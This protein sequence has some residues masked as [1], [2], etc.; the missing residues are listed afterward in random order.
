[1]IAAMTSTTDRGA[2]LHPTIAPEE[3]DVRHQFFVRSNPAAGRED[4]YNRWY[5][6][7]HLPDVLRIP[8][9]VSAQ[10]FRITAPH[11]DEPAPEFS[12]LAIY[13]IDTE[14]LP[15]VM[16]QLRLR[17]GTP[18]MMMSDALDL[19]TTSGFMGTPIGPRRIAGKS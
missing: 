10:R 4:D 1:M 14:D 18:A 15:A 7:V 19:A 13:E 2:A 11:P 16:E 12:Y 9:M 3:N 17:I 5:D 6:E 8:G